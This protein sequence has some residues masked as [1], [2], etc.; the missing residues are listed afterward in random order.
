M[1]KI[2]EA[3]NKRAT[4]LIIND[5]SANE[6]VE[7]KFVAAG[8]WQFTGSIKGCDKFIEHDLIQRKWTGPGAVLGLSKC[9]INHRGLSVL[10][11]HKH[12]RLNGEDGQ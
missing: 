7:L 3:L 1:S 8:P 10:T 12:N 11:Y 9:A 6:L 2:L 4:Q 5:L